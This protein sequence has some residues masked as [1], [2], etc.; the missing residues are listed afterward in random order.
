MF[1]KNYKNAFPDAYNSFDREFRKRFVKI[2][3]DIN[4]KGKMRYNRSGIKT[5]EIKAAIE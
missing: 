1:D 2:S 3:N 4:L 5:F